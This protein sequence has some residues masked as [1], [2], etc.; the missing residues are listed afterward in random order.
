MA[1]ACGS[2]LLS[3]QADEHAGEAGRGGAH[4]EADSAALLQHAAPP[5]RLSCACGGCSMVE[6]CDLQVSVCVA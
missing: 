1:C 5:R 6:G 2:A 4:L 3:W